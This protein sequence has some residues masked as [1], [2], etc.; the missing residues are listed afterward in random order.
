MAP[1]GTSSTLATAVTSALIDAIASRTTSPTLTTASATTATS[2]PSPTT[3]SAAAAQTEKQKKIMYWVLFNPLS[4]LIYC[5]ILYGILKLAKYCLI[6]RPRRHRVTRNSRI[7]NE[8]QRLQSIQREQEQ[9]RYQ[10]QNAWEPAEPVDLPSARRDADPDKAIAFETD[11]AEQ[12]KQTDTKTVEMA[13]A[14]AQDVDS[15]DESTLHDCNIDYGE[16]VVTR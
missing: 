8:S 11:L 3:S 2:S 10:Q 5:A 1:T 16:D 6:V 12:T 7:Q 4:I 15:G 9:R 14:D 13:L